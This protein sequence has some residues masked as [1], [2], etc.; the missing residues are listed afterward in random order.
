V[1]QGIHKSK[2][3]YIFILNPD[4]QIEAETINGL[5]NK[6]NSNPK[7]A[8]AAPQLRFLDGR[9][10]LSCR[11]FPTH[12]NVLVEI[13]SINQFTRF[14]GWK[15][16]SFNHKTELTV[17]QAA[18][19]ALFVRRTILNDLSA[20]DERFPMFFSDVDLCKRIKDLGFIIRFYP[21]IIVHHKGGSTIIKRRVAMIITSHISMI[22]YF[23]KHY[24]GL[25]YLMPN[26]LMAI[27]LFVG[28]PARILIYFVLPNKQRMKRTL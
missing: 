20:L 12:L 16:R 6:L 8:A 26:I 28:I 10:Q 23:F 19:A 17:D 2:G 14:E 1:N 11:R 4:T 24:N 21:D 25:R 9:V 13:M 5:T 22:K 7:V 15:M 3:D 27:S 18:G